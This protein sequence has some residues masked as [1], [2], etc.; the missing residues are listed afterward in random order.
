MAIAMID[1]V[2]RDATRL[3]PARL[4][5]LGYKGR[6]E[7][8]KI[9]VSVARVRPVETFDFNTREALHR[10]AGLI[11]AG[12]AVPYASKVILPGHTEPKKGMSTFSWAAL[13][14]AEGFMKVVGGLLGRDLPSMDL[15]CLVMNDS[16]VKKEKPKGFS[17]PPGWL[18]TPT[19]APAPQPEEEVDPTPS[20][21]ELDI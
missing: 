9:L 2:L 21:I 3:H 12:E 8:D 6:I 13:G 18:S 4:S 5:N 19:P 1:S 15:S 20:G 11:Q 16:Q 14:K 10:L 17:L 7:G